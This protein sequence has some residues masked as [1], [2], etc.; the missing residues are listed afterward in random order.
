MKQLNYA[1]VLI[2]RHMTSI[3]YYSKKK[4]C[5]PSLTRES[6]SKVA[7]NIDDFTYLV[8]V[9]RTPMKHLFDLLF[10]SYFIFNCI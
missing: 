8:K 9:A 7:V 5:R 3:F 4:Y 6:R 1:E 2:T 10:K